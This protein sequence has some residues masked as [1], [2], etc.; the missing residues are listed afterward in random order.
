VWAGGCAAAAEEE[1]SNGFDSS[2]ITG[3]CSFSPFFFS[4]VPLFFFSIL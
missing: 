2:D 4:L 3:V 1:T